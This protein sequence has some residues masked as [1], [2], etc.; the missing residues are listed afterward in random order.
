MCSS[1]Y[2]NPLITLRASV[3]H[4]Y[5]QLEIL[6]LLCKIL[7]LSWWLVSLCCPFSTFDFSSRPFVFSHIHVFFLRNAFSQTTLR[8]NMNYM[9]KLL[10]TTNIS[11]QSFLMFLLK[12][13]VDQFLVLWRIQ[14]GTILEINTII[15]S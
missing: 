9:C 1:S 14:S 15:S 6:M 3:K 2:K 4:T 13:L 7:L 12:I 8:I 5:S 10:E 11:C